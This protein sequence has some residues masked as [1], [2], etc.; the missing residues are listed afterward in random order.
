[1]PVDRMWSVGI[2]VLPRDDR[3]TPENSFV[4]LSMILG[5]LHS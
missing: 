4:H 3:Q 5:Y 1:M 2:E